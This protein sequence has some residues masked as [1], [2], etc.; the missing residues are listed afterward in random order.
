MP[1]ATFT[2]SIYHI[3]NKP[4]PHLY[5]P[6]VINGSSYDDVL[7]GSNL[8]DS[9]SGFEG[10][11]KLYGGMGDDW[12][13]GGDSAWWDSDYLYGGEGSDW[14]EGGSG[15]DHLYGESGNDYLYGGYDNDYL[16]GGD[17]D[18]YLY[19]GHG[20]DFLFGG[21]GADTYDFN[22]A[23]DSI[24]GGAR[25]WAEDNPQSDIIHDFN[26][27]E[28][29]KIDLSTIDANWSAVGNQAFNYTQL[30][31]NMSPAYQGEWVGTLTVDI[32]NGTDF[33]IVLMGSSASSFNP[34][35]DVIA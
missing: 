3:I 15:Q 14:L 1:L 9:I 35:F 18:D 22:S 4:L 24:F 28:A 6:N 27:K 11:D 7:H 5:K 31:Y 20:K 21:P 16:V 25:K 19:G 10:Q 26:S 33:Q 12:L 30:S 17:G 13:Y 2:D 29:D 34:F 8:D 23:S 32:F